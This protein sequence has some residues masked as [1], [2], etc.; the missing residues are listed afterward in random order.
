MLKRTHAIVLK[1]TP[2]GEADLIVSFFTYDF[3]LIKAFAKSPRKTKSR[4]GSSLEPLT[5]SRISLWGKE[6]ANLP[7]LTQSDIVLSFK[8]LREKLDCYMRVSEMVELILNFLPE[9]EAN[10]NVFKLFLNILKHIKKDSFTPLT[11]IL[12]KVQFLLLIGYEPHLQGCTCCGKS[13]LNFYISHGSIICE[14]CAKDMKSPIRLSPASIKLYE[15]LRTWN[16]SMVSRIKP[17]KT[18]L[19][20]ISDMIN[21]HIRYTLAKPLKT[22]PL[23]TAG[24]V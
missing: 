1:T 23:Y 3:G 22:T 9:A 2:F 13:G 24:K 19:S 7:R 6:F 15:N 21:D 17:S 8:T 12:F 10:K 5:C 20:E 4:F 16:V 18:I 14:N 11:I